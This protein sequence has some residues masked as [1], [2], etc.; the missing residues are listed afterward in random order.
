MT[1]SRDYGNMIEKTK[2]VDSSSSEEE[3]VK[4]SSKLDST[5][6]TGKN[7][8]RRIRPVIATDHMAGEQVVRKDEKPTTVWFSM[9]DLSEWMWKCHENII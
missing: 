7:E 9:K 6:I 5:Q 4:L 2:W 3:R 8:A 1:D